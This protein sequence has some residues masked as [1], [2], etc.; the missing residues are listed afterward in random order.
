MARVVDRRQLFQSQS[1]SNPM[2]V[3][4]QSFKVQRL[5]GWMEFP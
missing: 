4:V 5:D 3:E 2:P 1:S